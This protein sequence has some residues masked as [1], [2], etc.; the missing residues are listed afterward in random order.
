M[1]TIGWG[2]LAA[3]VG[4]GLSVY[5]FGGLWMTVQRAVAAEQPGALLLGSFVVRATGVMLGFAL[6]LLLIG[7][8]W[9]LLG[10]ALLGFIGTRAVLVRRWGEVPAQHPEAAPW[11]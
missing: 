8:R 6:V 10:A 11:R 3:G 2:L 4:A 9:E 5:Y 1:T 7:D